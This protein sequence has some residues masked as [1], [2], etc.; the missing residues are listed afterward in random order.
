MSCLQVTPGREQARRADDENL[1]TGCTHGQHSGINVREAG[2]PLSAAPGRR[3]NSA[4][5]HGCRGEVKG[6]LGGEEFRESASVRVQ[7]RKPPTKLS[8]IFPCE[9]KKTTTAS[10]P[11]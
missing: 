8:N 1:P 6:G 7:L 2:S 9:R 10:D 11:S 4:D 5:A 3:A